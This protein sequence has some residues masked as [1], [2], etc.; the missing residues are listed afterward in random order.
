MANKDLTINQI[1]RL[2]YN[3]ID[4]PI[5]K[6]RYIIRLKTYVD[7]IWEYLSR[8]DVEHSKE[9]HELFVEIVQEKIMGTSEIECEWT[10]NEYENF[11]EFKKEVVEISVNG[12]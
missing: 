5:H 11:V 4:M 10:E 8:Y 7:G 1:K 12:C 2:M 6:I 9:N 3:T